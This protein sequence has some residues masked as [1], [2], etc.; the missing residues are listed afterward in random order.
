MIFDDDKNLLYGS[1]KCAIK[2]ELE[3]KKVFKGLEISLQSMKL[4]ERS[5]IFCDKTYFDDKKDI[6]IEIE[7]INLGI[8]HYM[9]KG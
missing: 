4:G 5:L 6:Q 3:N 1:N 2:F 8:L 7:I 9:Y